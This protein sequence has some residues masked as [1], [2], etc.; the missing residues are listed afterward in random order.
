MSIRTDKI[1]SALKDLVHDL[2][3][4]EIDQSL[5]TR[6][7]RQAL[8]ALAL[9]KT[10]EGAEWRT[11]DELIQ[12]EGGKY[13]AKIRPVL[14]ETQE[15]VNEA[16]AD[17]T[18]GHRQWRMGDTIVVRDEPPFC[19]WPELTREQKINEALA[20]DIFNE[21]ERDMEL[22]DRLKSEGKCPVYCFDI[23]KCVRVFCVKP[24]GHTDEHAVR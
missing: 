9:P 15:M 6:L 22:A 12:R 21:A 2:Q 7:L 20:D 1:E 18:G 5:R 11:P 16:N 13:M 10:G 8:E 4:I 24:Y 3:R 23:V 17:K 14:L 19:G